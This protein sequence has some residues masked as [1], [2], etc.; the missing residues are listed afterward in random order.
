ME[1]NVFPFFRRAGKFGTGTDTDTLVG[2]Q[3]YKINAS[4][5]GGQRRDHLILPYALLFLLQQLLLQGQALLQFLLLY[6]GL[7]LKG[8]FFQFQPGGTAHLPQ[9][10]HK[11]SHQYGRGQKDLRQVARHHTVGN[12]TDLFTDQAFPD[13]VGKHPGCPLDRNIIHGFRD[14]IICERNITVFSPGKI[15]F[16][17]FQG[18]S[19][20]KDGGFHRLQQIGIGRQTA[21]YHIRQRDSGFCINVTKRGFVAIGLQ[22]NA[23]QHTLHVDFHEASNQRLPVKREFFQRNGDDYAFVFAFD[24]LYGNLRTCESPVIK[25]VGINIILQPLGRINQPVAVHKG[26]L[27]QS[28]QLFH[29]ALERLQMVYVLQIV[30]LKQTR[31]HLKIINRLFEIGRNDLFPPPCQFVKI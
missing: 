22:G 12:G 17:L 13:Q 4:V 11:H 6:P 31:C 8:F 15:L 21:Q 25:L 20:V 9:H 1:G 29:P 10:E 18:V 26:K 19:G 7:R 3:V 5:I 16:H 2:I 27:F 30:R 28:V 24:I 23:F 14:F